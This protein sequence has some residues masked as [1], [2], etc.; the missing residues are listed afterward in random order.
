[1]IFDHLCEDIYIDNP[2]IEVKEEVTDEMIVTS[3]LNEGFAA[4]FVYRGK[5]HTWDDDPISCFR[6]MDALTKAG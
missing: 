4:P 1:M 3:L 5:V 2:T 6:S